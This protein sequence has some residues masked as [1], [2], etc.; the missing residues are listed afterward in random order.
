MT[1]NQ[2]L[3]EGKSTL[4][5]TTSRTRCSCWASTSERRGSRARSSRRALRPSRPGPTWPWTSSS[6]NASPSPF[7]NANSNA[8]SIAT[9]LPPPPTR[10]S[11]LLASPATLSSRPLP[12]CPVPYSSPLLALS[13][14]FLSHCIL[15]VGIDWHKQ[16]AF[17]RKQMHQ[18][19]G[20]A[21]P[22]IF[23][24]EQIRKKHAVFALVQESLKCM[25]H[26][27]SPLT[28][29]LTYSL[30]QIIN[31]SINS[32]KMSSSFQK[33]PSSRYEKKMGEVNNNGA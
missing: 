10:T 22:I 29:Y 25:I 2:V 28:L 24:Y 19:V 12:S 21:S 23:K 33:N 17:V 1:S 9:C 16:A 6:A 3:Q 27:L 26:T 32:F 30:L 20:G 8:M 4:T 14:F 31:W 13:F 5:R 7:L 15:T 18:G 11:L